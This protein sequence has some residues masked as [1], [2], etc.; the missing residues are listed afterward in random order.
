[1]GEPER[2]PIRGDADF[3]SLLRKYADQKPATLPDVAA[4]QQTP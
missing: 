1:V 4:Q 3:Q 2:D